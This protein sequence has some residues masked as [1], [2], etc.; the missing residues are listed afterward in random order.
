MNVKAYEAAHLEGFCD[1]Q[2]RNHQ[3]RV[4][5]G[6]NDGW[7]LGTEHRPYY[8]LDENWQP[9][10]VTLKRRV[11]RAWFS[12]FFDVAMLGLRRK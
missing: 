4:D 10:P 2:S 8:E 1:G 6:Y 3:G 11:G 5:L 7:A 12:F 9:S